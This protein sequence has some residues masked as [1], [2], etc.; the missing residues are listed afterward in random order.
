[1]GE[2]EGREVIVDVHSHAWEYP[3]HFTDDFRRQAR[4]ARAGA[5]VDL[6]VRYE[7]YR[8]AAPA[9]TRTVVFGGEGRPRG[10][11][12]DDA[13]VAN[14][15][16]AHPDALVG[17]LSLDPTQQGWRRELEDG[18]RGLG[19]RGVKLMPMYAGFAPDDGRLDPL[20][21]Y[22]TRHRLPVLL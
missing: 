11:W 5:E 7:D 10:L 16:A 21:E 18:H 14:Y 1:P 17:F 3:A 2:G 12:V 13:Y 15:A 8:R 19:L 22:A 20:W 6:T 4:R 9:G